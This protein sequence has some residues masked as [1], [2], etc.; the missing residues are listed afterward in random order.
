MC[1]EK[2]C[3]NGSGVVSSYGGGMAGVVEAD[4]G[5]SGVSVERGLDGCHE[6]LAGS[7]GA[8]SRRDMS[9]DGM[10]CRCWN[11]GSGRCDAWWWL[12][13]EGWRYS[14]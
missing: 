14:A 3:G 11:G 4:R 1:G 10:G 13:G 6:G 7:C 9:V 8:E 12:D 2:R 5:I